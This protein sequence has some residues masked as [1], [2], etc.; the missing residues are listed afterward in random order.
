ML[1]I[2]IIL[3]VIL[4][5]IGGPLWPLQFLSGKA[6]GLGYIILIIWIILFIGG[7]NN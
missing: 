5:F 6:G 2:A 1:T 4:A 7:I 3:Y